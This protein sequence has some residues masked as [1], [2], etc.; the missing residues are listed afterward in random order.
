MGEEST[1]DCLAYYKR[2]HR[3]TGESGGGVSVCGC[4]RRQ[5][6]PGD[7]FAPAVGLAFHVYDR[8]DRTFRV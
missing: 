4:S 7:F 8:N 5:M 3:V 6:D 2:D 1:R